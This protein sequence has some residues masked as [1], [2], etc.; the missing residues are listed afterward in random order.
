MDE[1]RLVAAARLPGLRTDKNAKDVV[2]E[3]VQSGRPK[4][5][6]QGRRLR[7]KE[8][9]QAKGP[10]PKGKETAGPRTRLGQKRP[11]ARR[12]GRDDR[13]PKRPRS[14]R[15][16]RVALRRPDTSREDQERC[17]RHAVERRLAAVDESGEGL[18]AEARHHQGRAA[19]L[20]RAG[21]AVPPAV[22]RRPAAGDEAVSERRRWAA[23]YQQRHPEKTPPGVRRE[24]LPDHIEPIDEEGPRDRLIGGSLTTLLYMTQLA[25][26]SQD[27]GSRASPTR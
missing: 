16:S 5:E 22:R 7:A 27:P 1:R 8:K 14:R 21:I 11:E 3:D 4:A 15:G 24:V 19:P 17:R 12:A 25:A 6:G 23:F 9:A 20:L 10:R 18:L 2:R 13:G 26:I